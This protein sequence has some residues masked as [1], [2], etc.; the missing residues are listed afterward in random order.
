MQRA[1]NYSDLSPPAATQLILESDWIC[2]QYSKKL[3][4]VG[5]DIAFRRMGQ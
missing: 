2:E 4:E 3:P 1:G 5:W